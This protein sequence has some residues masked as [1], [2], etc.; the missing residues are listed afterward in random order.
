[1]EDAVT[2]L[3]D[4]K[5]R[6]CVKFWWGAPAVK[7]THPENKLP[8]PMLLAC[9]T[10][11]IVARRAGLCRRPVGENLLVIKYSTLPS[12]GKLTRRGLVWMRAGYD[13]VGS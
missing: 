3:Q 4:I 6:P 1:M 5:L 9:M 7:L 10:T 8:I 13:S 12:S 11:I 2:I